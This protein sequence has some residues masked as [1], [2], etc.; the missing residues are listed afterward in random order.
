VTLEDRVRGLAE[1]HGL[2]QSAA[3]RLLRLARALAAEPDPPTTIRSPDEIVDRHLADSLA[4]LDLPVVPGSRRLADI[5]SGAGFP[6]LPLAIALPNASVDLVEA[7]RR[8]CDVIERLARGSGVANATAVTARVETW[9]TVEGRA[10]YDAVTARA[11]GSLSVL[12]EYAAPL[13]AVDGE[14]VAW[15]GRRNSDEER[16]GEAAAAQ[17]G[18]EYAEV[19]PVMPFPEARDRHLH[20]FVKREPTPREYPRRP[21]RAV[22][23]PLA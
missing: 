23:R 12:V 4:A 19:V 3:D 7:S 13:L 18:L 6:G 8:T 17:L 10:A 20:R 21:G 11:V 2:P 1:V 9:A 15:K 22:K 16:A 14:L 5:G